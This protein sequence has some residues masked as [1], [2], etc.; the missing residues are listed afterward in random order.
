MT[1]ILFI[2]LAAVVF[3]GAVIGG[4]AFF[5]ND[6][7]NIKKVG[8]VDIGGPFSLVDHTGKAVTDQDYAGKFMLVYF[9]YTFCPDV[10]PTSLSIMGDALN[11]LSPDQLDK[12]A[13]IFVTVDPERDTPEVLAGYVPNFHEKMIGLTGDLKNIKAVAKAYKVFFAKANQDDPDGNYTMD[14]GSTTYLIG[15]DGGYVAHFSHG[16]SSKMI[17][18]KLAE[19][20]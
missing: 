8:T 20:L 5:L 2:A 3:V 12:V 1:R 7:S 9:G 11:M 19:I 18:E 15:P 13:P 16:S 14:H 17:A 6:R 4:K 10:C